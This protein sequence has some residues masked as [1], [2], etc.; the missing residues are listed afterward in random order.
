[1]EPLGF[2]SVRYV[3]PEEFHRFVEDRE[4]AG[5]IN[6]YELLNGRVVMNPPAGWPHGA[7]ENEIQ[8][9]LSNWVRRKAIGI[10][11]GSSQGF[12]L[13]SGDVVAPDYS[14]VTHE[15]FRAASPRTG[16]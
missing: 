3:T 4:R 5:D 8:W 13:P 15:R 7:V 1:M 6:G 10:L 12:E 2:E 11:F 16:E 9:V 14:F